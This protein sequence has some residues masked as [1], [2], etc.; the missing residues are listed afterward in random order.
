MK[1]TSF[2]ELKKGDVFRLHPEGEDCIFWEKFNPCRPLYRFSDQQYNTANFDAIGFL[3]KNWYS[4]EIRD[5]SRVTRIWEVVCCKTHAI[6]GVGYTA[7][8]AVW[9]A[10]LNL[11]SQSRWWKIWSASKDDYVFYETVTKRFYWAAK[12]T[13]IFIQS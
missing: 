12:E 10:G 2:T 13:E 9:Q 4:L 8:E 7:L 6:K 1:R 3:Q 5:V 11:D